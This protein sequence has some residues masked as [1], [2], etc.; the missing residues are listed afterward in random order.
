MI[1]HCIPVT[2]SSARLRLPMLGSAA[3]GDVCLEG[4]YAGVGTASS[5]CDVS[6]PAAVKGDTFPGVRAWSPP[7]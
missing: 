5:I 7:V 2:T 1:T 3:R 6:V 4:R